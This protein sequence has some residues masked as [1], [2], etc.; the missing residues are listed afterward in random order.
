MTV[1]A[2]HALIGEGGPLR[3][4]EARCHLTRPLAQILAALAIA[5][6]P[7]MVL[8][9]I[10]ESTTQQRVWLLR[11]QVMHVRMLVAMPILLFLDR[12]F[13]LACSHAIAQL[14]QNG[15][16][17]DAD[18]PRFARLLGRTKQL[19]EWALPEIVLAV[20]ALVLGVATLTIGGS[21]RGGRWLL[22]DVS[23]AN[24]WYA[25]VG[26][27]LFEF[28]LFR[29]LWRWAIWVRALVGISR[30]DLDLDATHPDR[31]G[32]IS[33]LRRPSIA[34][35]AMLLFAAS[36]VLSAGWAD[37]FQ[38]VTL[39]SFIPLL[40]VLAVVGIVLAF[41]PL[42][43]FATKLQRTRLAAHDALSGLAVRNGRWF[44]ERWLPTAG[45][46]ALASSD[47]Q[48]LAAIAST[49]RDT[50]QQ[51]RIVP[52]DKKD[53]L[54]VLAATLAPVLPSMIVRIPHAEW[55]TMAAFMFGTGLP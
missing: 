24:W 1:A 41:G 45:G 15:F 53:L 42:L 39:T 8:G 14:T 21:L 26:L 23:L 25:L 40:L 10:T 2:A 12:V 33:F 55:F 11:D 36:T 4:V 43:V 54:L 32:G 34:Y 37:R 38:F 6:L 16:V 9:F 46:E 20:T 5:W 27:P 28:L 31:R 13:P 30:L 3:R 50:V 22:P 18:Q 17:K 51:I 29:S 48:S 19:S 49:Y 35:C 7:I 52:F 44:R 47:V